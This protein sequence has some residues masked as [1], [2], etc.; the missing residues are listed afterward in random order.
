MAGT[1]IF[2][3]PL[4]MVQSTQNSGSVSQGWRTS[5]ARAADAAG[6]SRTASETFGHYS[7]MQA[8]GTTAEADFC[9]VRPPEPS[10][11]RVAPDPLP[12]TS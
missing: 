4:K 5:D 2:A 10:K 6:S 9:M 8:L 7:S 12:S 11:L 1:G 3:E